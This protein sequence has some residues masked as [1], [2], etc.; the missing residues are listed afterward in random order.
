M[1]ELQQ[2]EGDLRFVRGALTSSERAGSP[3]AIYFLWAVAA[4]IGFS[5]VDFRRDLVGPF[6]TIVGPAGF[7]VSLY[8]GWR[9]AQKVGQ[10]SA[11][12]GRRH[13][14]HWGGMLAAVA[15]AGLLPARG[16]VPWEV[17][18]S[19]ILLILAFGY[20]SAG[21]H[22]DRELM[23]VGVVMGGGYLLVTLASAFAWTIAGVAIAV[24]LT[25]AG[26][27]ARRSLEATP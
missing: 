13:A 19:V 27:H 26:L 16:V 21:V 5:L 23:W 15:L 24:A 6:W 7:V 20:F 14:L 11:A 12:E 18:N 22:G 1:T 8:I 17:M 2:I 4:L 25:V 9:H 3:A 10:V